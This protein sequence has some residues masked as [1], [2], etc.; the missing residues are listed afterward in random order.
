MAVLS[1]YTIFANVRKGI[2]YVVILIVAGCATS[3]NT[4]ALLNQQI[5]GMRADSLLLE[6]RI[7]TL[8]EENHFL[9]EKCAVIEQAYINRLQE[10]ED[11]LLQ[12]RNELN[13]RELMLV[14]M[15]NRKL[16]EK[17]AFDKLT[18]SIFNAYKDLNLGMEN[19]SFRN[20]C[21]FIEIEMSD[22][23]FFVG[24][25]L[26]PEATQNSLLNRTRQLLENNKDLQLHITSYCDSVFVTKDKTEDA[27]SWSTI[28]SNTITRNLLKEGNTNPTRVT[29]AGKGYHTIIDK[30]N[31]SLGRNKV[32]FS[33]Y[34]NLLPCVYK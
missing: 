28:K 29:S 26:K 25:T 16:E 24:S 13:Q 31:V 14:D 4:I 34:S 22:K 6:K 1:K 27:L 23:L 21:N 20:N 33:F 11:S 12:K 5:E 15:Q 7:S 10:K 18:L 2:L 17:D 8:S 19:F 9:S 30:Q 3:K 32:V